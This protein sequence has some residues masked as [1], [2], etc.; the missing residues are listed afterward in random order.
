MTSPRWIRESLANARQ[1]VGIGY[2]FFHGASLQPIGESSIPGT[3]GAGGPSDPNTPFYA[4]HAEIR[5]AERELESRGEQ[6]GHDEN[7]ESDE[8]DEG[9]S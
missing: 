1:Y 3:P 6:V 7:L 2:D 8:D 9:K 4:Q 5:D